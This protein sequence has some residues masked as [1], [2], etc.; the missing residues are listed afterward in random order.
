MSQLTDRLRA[1]AASVTFSEREQ[2]D[3]RDAARLME[4]AQA[5]FNEPTQRNVAS[6]S[7]HIKA[8]RLP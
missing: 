1:L 4:L 7:S 3:I 8:L 5:W 6:L 2:Q